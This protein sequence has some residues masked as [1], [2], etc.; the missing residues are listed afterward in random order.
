MC[1]AYAPQFFALDDDGNSAI[2][3]AKPVPPGLE[4]TVRLGI[5]SCPEQA[6]SSE[7]H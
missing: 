6:L 2:G 3:T 5:D 7:D 1:E 4:D